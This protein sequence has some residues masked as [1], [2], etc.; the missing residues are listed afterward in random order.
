[1]HRTSPITRRQ[2]L[3]ISAAACGSVML[4]S[5]GYAAMDG[6]KPVS[7]RGI[8]LGAPA[9]I[10]LYSTSRK[11]GREIL[12][13]AVA[14]LSRLEA[15]FSLYQK[16]SAISRLN[17]FG[18]IHNPSHDLIRLVS[19][20]KGVSRATG[21]AFDPTIQPLWALYA[22]HFARHPEQD[23]GPSAKQIAGILELVD[24]HAVTITPD[25]IAFNKH[26]M[27]LSLNGIA[28]GY[29]TDRIADLLRREGLHHVLIDMGETRGLGSHPSGRPWRV[30]IGSPDSNGEIIREVE[31]IDKAVATSAPLGTPFESKGKFHHLLDPRTGQCAS[32]Y[33]SVTV[34]APNAT[35]ADAYSTAFAAMAWSDV[36]DRVMKISGM[37]V[38]A[39]DAQ[40]AWLVARG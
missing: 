13:Q 8:A 24:N 37:R 19:S 4:S 26:G 1:M 16:K 18:E 12:R 3:H 14:E 9:E 30:G 38:D 17:R 2:M 28:Q 11:A 7:W 22:E 5:T 15:V 6:V 39:L 32:L 36:R 34:T 23:Q 20:A 31:L 29:I 35:L 10:K 33:K 27:G 40:G 21:G 25:R